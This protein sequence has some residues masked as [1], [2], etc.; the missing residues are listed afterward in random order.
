MFILSAE[1][2]ASAPEAEQCFERYRNH[3][4]RNRAV[5]PPGAYELAASSWYH[6]FT[7]HRA[8][9]D[10]WLEAVTIE[11]PASG[12]RQELR[13]VTLRI[14]LL[15]AYH[16]GHIE[17]LYPRV[18]RYHLDLERG[19]QG[20]RDWRYDEFRLNADGNLVHEIEWAGMNDTGR[21]VIE[22]SDVEFKW[23]PLNPGHDAPAV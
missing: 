6:G 18:F 2:D 15:G 3:L 11:E 23:Y 14:R 4:E 16:D 10:A 9:H 13:T 12:L 20:H 17:L 8:P 7:D 21:W 5:F 1:R 19:A 22:A